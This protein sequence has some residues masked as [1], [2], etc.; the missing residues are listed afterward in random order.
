MSLI[1]EGQRTF[2]RE[3]YL[4]PSEARLISLKIRQSAELSERLT[5]SQEV[6]GSVPVSSTSLFYLLPLV[7]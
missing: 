4:H 6:A 1:R 2:E 7:F 3:D 5:G